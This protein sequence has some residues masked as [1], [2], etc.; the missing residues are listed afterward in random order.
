[1][2]FPLRRAAVLVLTAGLAVSAFGPSLSTQGAHAATPRAS[3]GILRIAD[4]G[5]ND[6][7]SIDP[8]S[9]AAS[10][11]PSNVVE[12]LV[13]AGLL[14]LDEKLQ[15][16]PDGA[17]SWKVTNDGRTYTFT[18]RPGLTF[19]D[20]V[21]VTAADVVYT[22]NR[23]FAPANASGLTDY[24][25]GH[26]VGG[27]AVTNKKAKT[28]SG[29]K[30]IGTNKV[31]ITLDQPE[32]VFLN[33]I[34][35]VVSS[36]VPRHVIEKYGDKS[37]I[38]HAVGTGPFYVK[39]WKHRQEVDLAPNPYYW[40][41]KPKL[42]GVNVLFIQNTETAYNLYQTGGV[43]VMGL[44][45]FPGNHIKDVKG[46]PGTHEH[47]HLLTEYLQ[48]NTRRKPFNNTLVRRAFSY[49]VNRATIAKLLNDRVLPAHSILPPGMPGYNKTA[50]GQTF[51]PTLA[52]QLLAKAGY[53]NGKGFPKVT[54]AVNGGDPDGPTKANALREFWKRF[55]HVDVA[56]NQMEYNAY[57]AA[58]NARTL[59]M[60]FI[61]WGADYPDPQDFL[62]LLL[63]TGAGGNNG[64]WHNATFD[65]LT[66]LADVMPHD[67][68]KRYAMYQQAEQIAL[69]DVAVMVLD[70][71]KD[72]ILINPAVHGL[73]TNSLGLVAPNWADV[74]K[75]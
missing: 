62:S 47:A 13:F 33:Q 5:V 24:Y 51:N 12:S 1:M 15:V 28:V 26:I 37:W 68:P 35:Y 48:F 42:K 25:L 32:A 52:Q 7:A 66:K 60:D 2:R 21:P 30:A 3:S 59:D 45:N 10:N 71:Q 46:K 4:E 49:A 58:L 41:G 40:R 53:P 65:R 56:I 14:R 74:T 54:L 72:Y 11:A 18:L 23:A 50:P 63:Q 57:I 22:F 27:L 19:A 64:G 16:Q 34:A 31:Q 55:L 17:S 70:W 75:S 9:P 8:P 43:D 73:T 20:G 67:S 39:Q 36:I 38:D 29:V 69:N 6:L 44:I 61:Q